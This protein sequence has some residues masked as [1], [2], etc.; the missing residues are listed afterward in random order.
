MAAPAAEQTEEMRDYAGRLNAA[1]FAGNLT[2]FSA[3]DA[4]YRKLCSSAD[5][6]ALYFE[7]IRS[8]LG[9]NYTKLR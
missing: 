3:D 2:D 1:Y 5:I 6:T 4:M 7:S 9:Q 8:D